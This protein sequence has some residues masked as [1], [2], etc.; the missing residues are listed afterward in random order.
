MYTWFIRSSSNHIHVFSMVVQSHSFIRW[1]SNHILVFARL[2]RRFTEGV[3]TFSMQLGIAVV[4][5]SKQTRVG[6]SFNCA[7][8]HCIGHDDPC[9]AVIP[10]APIRVFSIFMAAMIMFDYLYDITIF[11]ACLMFQHRLLLKMEEARQSG[12]GGCGGGC[13]LMALDFWAWVEQRRQRRGGEERRGGGGGGEGEGKHHDADPEKNAQ[14]HEPTTTTTKKKDDESEADA[15][16]SE[17]F[18]RDRVYPALHAGGNVTSSSIRSSIHPTT[19]KPSFSSVS[20]LNS[21]CLTVALHMDQWTNEWTN[22]WT[23]KWTN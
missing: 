6:G 23:N 22:E 19:D 16:L 4:R 18:F 8:V 10:I 2:K 21:Q 3:Y 15:P 14:K 7:G 13:T 17:R 5:G 1:S 20:S 9:S 12:G 11:A